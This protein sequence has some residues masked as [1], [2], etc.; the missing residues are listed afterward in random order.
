MHGFPRAVAA[1][2]TLALLVALPAH[3][4]EKLPPG[5]HTI[6]LEETAWLIDRAELNDAISEKTKNQR[7]EAQ[8]KQCSDALAKAQVAPPP[9]KNYT[10]F[11]VGAWAVSVT[12]AFVGG[13]YVFSKID[14]ENRT[15]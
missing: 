3:A 12:G 11:I 4:A 1:L 9:E 6:I 5:T 2:T 15:R 13:A 10:P 8:L 14:S 7:L